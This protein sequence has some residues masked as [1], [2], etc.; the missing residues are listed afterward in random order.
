MVDDTVLIFGK[1]SCPYTQDAR[2]DFARRKVKVQYINVKKD[3]AGL[4]RM[5]DYSGGRRQV[6]VIVEGGKVTVGFG[7][8]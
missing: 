3:A 7:G 1:D 8:T 5:L 6:P 2:D 4:Q